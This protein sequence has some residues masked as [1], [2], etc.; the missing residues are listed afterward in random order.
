MRHEGEWLWC[1]WTGVLDWHGSGAGQFHPRDSGLYH[2]LRSDN[3][4]FS[5]INARSLQHIK[6]FI[7]LFLWQGMFRRP[8]QLILGVVLFL[9]WNLASSNYICIGCD[10]RFRL[11]KL[12]LLNHP[13]PSFGITKNYSC[14]YW[15]LWKF[16]SYNCV[17]HSLEFGKSHC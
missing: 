6:Y 4:K 2:F 13:G 3:Y 8:P 1:S 15:Y 17:G 5:R 10:W 12:Q 11:L 16:L 9:M 14:R 7:I